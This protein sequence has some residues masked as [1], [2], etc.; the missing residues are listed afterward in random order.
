MSVAADA[1]APT[2]TVS[3]A[4][5]TEDQAIALDITSALSDASETLSITISGVPAG[6]SLSAG[7]DNGDGSWTLETGDLAGLSITPAA[8]SDADFTLSVTATS[9]DGSDTASTL[10]SIDV[11]V[12]ADADAPTLDATVGSRTINAQETGS[13]SGYGGGSGGL[14]A[15]VYDLDITAGLADADGSEMLLITISGLPSGVTLSAGTDNGDGSWTLASGD[16]A[17]LTMTVA[18]GSGSDFSLT[19]SATSTEADGG[20][21]ATTTAT[22]DIDLVDSIVEGSSGRDNMTGSDGDDAMYGFGNK[23]TIHGGDGNDIIDGGDKDDKLYGDDGDDTLIGGDGNDKLYGGGGD[24]TLDGGAGDD[25]MDG[26]A[27]DDTFEGGLGDD[28]V[29]GGDGNDLFIFGT[30][31]G[32]DTF[33]GG[34]GWTDTVQ[35][36][37]VGGGPDAGAGWT[38]TTEEG[39]TVDADGSGLTFEGE[40]SGTI[41][42]QD[43]SKLDFN[44][45]DKIEW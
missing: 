8:D 10:G 2:L 25:I 11:S 37:D 4:S 45:V 44:G 20:G 9:T 30:G 19:V 36:E 41:T 29:L 21:A 24:D 33:D 23:D 16:L 34:S 27:G 6:A 28:T 5:G 39:Y 43:G 32:S 7:T 22:I 1:D 35:L 3:D 13:G 31:D 17:D 26:G 42:L 38:L 40:A 15:A 18:D 12:A 14:T